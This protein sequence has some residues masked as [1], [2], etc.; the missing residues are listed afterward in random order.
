MEQKFSEVK[1]HIRSGFSLMEVSIVLGVLAILIAIAIPNFLR[2]RGHQ[3]V[4]SAAELT[5]GMIVRAKEEAKAS[6][7][8]L[9]ETL[10]KTGPNEGLNGRHEGSF[11]LRIR[12]RYR[13]GEPIQTVSHRELPDSATLDIELSN[14]GL[15]DLDSDANLI[16]VYF[17]IVRTKPSTEILAVIPI[18]A[19]GEFC[20]P[21]A[22]NLATIHFFY[23][24]Y[25]RAIS[26]T[27]RGIS[28]PDRR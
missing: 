9:P 7:F 4:N 18:D 5:D 12:K 14:F 3:T 6:G 28:R 20:L 24:S 15:V 23:S 13:A 17:E 16:G 10:R 11:S 22:H 26:V 8:A 27:R 1:Q 2:Y 19:N 21:D 25:Q